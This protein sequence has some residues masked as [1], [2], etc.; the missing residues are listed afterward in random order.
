MRKAIAGLKSRGGRV[1][2]LDA[3]LGSNGLDVTQ[4]ISPKKR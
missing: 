4:I 1:E 3:Y 2:P